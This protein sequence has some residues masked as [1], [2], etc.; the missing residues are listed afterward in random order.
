[1]VEQACNIACNIAQ[2]RDAAK[3]NDIKTGE[4]RSAFLPGWG[5]FLSLLVATGH[6]A[7]GRS[8][9]KRPKAAGRLTPSP[10]FLGFLYIAE[11]VHK[12][13]ST[14]ARVVE[15]IERHDAGVIGPNG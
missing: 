12:Q 15:Q 13:C 2:R 5:F 14:Q 9:Q 10:L 7:G 6:A 4:N 3:R 8:P 1:M 11:L